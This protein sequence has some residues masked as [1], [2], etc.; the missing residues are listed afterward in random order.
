MREFILNHPDY[1]GDSVV[2]DSI[3]YDLLQ[4]C[5]AVAAGELDAP[6]L[7]GH[8]RLPDRPHLNPSVSAGRR[9]GS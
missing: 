8:N 7:I 2:S 1:K 5:H 6:T 3:T 9:R 4:R